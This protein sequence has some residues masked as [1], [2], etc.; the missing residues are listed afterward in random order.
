MIKASTSLSF[1]LAAAACGGGA[2][3]TG[4][5][6]SFG[7][8]LSDGA[9]TDGATDDGHESETDGELVISIEL[10]PAYAVIEVH[11]G[12]VPDPLPFTAIGTTA[13]GEVIPVSGVWSFDR[14]DLADFTGSSLAATGLAGG[15]GTVTFESAVGEATTTATIKLFVIDDPIDVDPAIEDA[16]DDATTPDPALDLLYPYDE[17]VFPRG[18]AGPTMMWNGGGSE[19]VYRIRLYSSTFDYT[20]YAV[21]PPPSRF[22]L[23]LAPADVW[24]QLSDSVT[25]PFAVEVQRYDGQ[26]A[27]LAKAQTWTMSTANLRGAIYYWEVENGAVVRLDPGAAAPATFLQTEG[28][29]VACHSVSRDGSTI[30][31]SLN[32]NGN[33]YASPWATYDATSGESLYSTLS[34]ST[35]GNPSGF[36][37]ISPEGDYVL[38]RQWADAASTP[39]SMVLS[40]SGSSIPLAYLETPGGTPTHP[41]WS[42]DGRS[43]AFGVRTE[44][45][46]LDF[47]QSNL[48]T[49]S[50]ELGTD[51]PQ[52]SNL[53]QIVANDPTRPTLTY[54]TYSPDSQ[55]IAFMRATKSRTRSYAATAETPESRC[56]AELWLTNTDGSVQLLLDAA[57][58]V[59]SAA[60]EQQHLSFEPTFSPVAAGGYFWLVFVSERTYGNRLTDTSLAGRRKQLW[61]TAIDAAPT[62]GEDP[63]HPAF[64]MPGQSLEQGNMRG[65]WALSPCKGLGAPCEAGYECCEGFCLYD[66]E[67]GD[68]VCGEP[69]S[70]GQLE[71]ACETNADCCDPMAVCIGGYCSEPFIP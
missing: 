22:E 50:I 26:N 49:A 39:S 48:W 51:P 6:G 10:E 5:S 20:G 70:C 53:R 36:Q 56:E 7:A 55:W 63:S 35:Y 8:G 67:V 11:D 60:A 54:P 1:L 27:Y 3:D 12:T 23:P 57:N 4:F 45:N 64:W 14:P 52:F 30:V 24:R 2:P 66:P 41:S 28:A 13:S 33:G 32:G 71:D 29:C 68:T 38:W 58:R 31:A 9:T 37:A 43:V 19:D 47:V 69:Q 25:G 42:A 15:T 59:P 40:E 65:N 62:A 46:G 16:F 21:V 18:L 34:E 61:V 17:T 44:G